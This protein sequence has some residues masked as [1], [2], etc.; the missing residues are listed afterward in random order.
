LYLGYWIKNSQKMAYKENY[1]S[2]EAL[3]DGE[4]LKIK[5]IKP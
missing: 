2:Q 5:H 4:W 3:I 1:G